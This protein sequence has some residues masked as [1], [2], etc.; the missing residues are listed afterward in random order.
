MRPASPG[1]SMPE[2]ARAAATSVE[3]KGVGGAADATGMRT[4]VLGSSR[5]SGC[6][7]IK[8]GRARL[9][10]GS[11]RPQQPHQ[12]QHDPPKHPSPLAEAARPCQ[13]TGPDVAVL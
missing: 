4:M 9:S 5:T 2:S 8:L 3:I 13:P 1:K 10:R 6:P 11:K 7:P 12:D